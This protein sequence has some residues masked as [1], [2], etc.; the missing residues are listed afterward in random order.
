MKS[1]YSYC[2][3]I[4]PA[5]KKKLYNYS[6][7]KKAFLF[8]TIFLFLFSVLNAQEQKTEYKVIFHGDSVGN[9]LVCKN[10]TEDNIS[11]TMVSNVLIRFL[12]KVKV[13]S[14][15]ESNFQSGTLMYS[16]VSR[17]VNGKEKA[18]KQIKAIGNTYQATSFGKAVP[19]IN[20]L[21]DYNLNMLYCQ[22]PFNKQTAY[23]DNFQKFLTVEE[24]AL[25]KYKIML[26]DGNYNYYTFNNGICSMVELHHSFYTVYIQR[27]A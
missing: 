1:P 27:K 10:K 9:M 22:E 24:V 16:N 23:S 11:F 12:I 2:L 17:I 19:S 13:V 6:R 4:L 18:A 26:P 25:H 21:I 5:S 7:F 20:K 14:K 3:F 8:L 15:E